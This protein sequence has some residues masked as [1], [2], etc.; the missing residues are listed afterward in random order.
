MWAILFLT[1]RGVK[2]PLHPADE[3]DDGSAR[4]RGTYFRAAF[5]EQECGTRVET[6]VYGDIKL[7]HRCRYDVEGRLREASVACAGDD[8]QVV[9]L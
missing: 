3:L 1:Y 2:L 4:H 9:T 8:R 6:R 7:E 5:D